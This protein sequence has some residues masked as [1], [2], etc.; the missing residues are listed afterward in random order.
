MLEL[1]AVLRRLLN[2]LSGDGFSETSVV[3]EPVR[4]QPRA[5]SAQAEFMRPTQRGQKR[6]PRSICTSLRDLGEL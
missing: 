6:Q 1:R 5:Q 2:V 4:I 3:F